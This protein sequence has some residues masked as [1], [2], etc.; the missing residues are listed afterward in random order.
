ML[1]A[2]KP[3][4]IPGLEFSSNDVFI[5]EE[6]FLLDTVQPYHPWIDIQNE[7]SE[8]IIII[9]E[10][11]LHHLP[12]TTTA[13]PLTEIPFKTTD[14]EIISKPDDTSTDLTFITE[15]KLFKKFFTILSS[16]SMSIVIQGKLYVFRVGLR[17]CLS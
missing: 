17:R 15:S 16:N 9:L 11:K 10:D 14:V 4:D 2:E 5:K 1:A 7:A 6:D 13:T 12:L 3:P 8:N